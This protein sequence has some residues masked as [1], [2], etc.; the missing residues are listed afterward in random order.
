VNEQ[1]DAIKNNKMKRI[2]SKL[3]LVVIRWN[4]SNVKMSK[5]CKHCISYIKRIGIKK[6]YYSD[7]QSFIYSKVSQL[8]SNHVSMVWKVINKLRVD[9]LRVDK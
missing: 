1:K 9:K 2:M 6:I 5:P 7:E 4:G 3:T 8:E